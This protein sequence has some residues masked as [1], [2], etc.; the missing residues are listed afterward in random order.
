MKLI[1]TIE[2]DFL[3]KRKSRTE[4]ITTICN[5]MLQMIENAFTTDF[6]GR[7]P[8]ILQPIN[9]N[10]VEVQTQ[11]ATSSS[12]AD[13]RISAMEEEVHVLKEQRATTDSV[14]ISYAQRLYNLDIWM[15]MGG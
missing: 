6:D 11:L 12:A 9:S 10:L 8:T 5:E 7:I 3:S 1:L 4:A 14:L 13:Y 15:S 2:S